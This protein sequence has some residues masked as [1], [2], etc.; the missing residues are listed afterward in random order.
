MNRK[1]R[2][3][4]AQKVKAQVTLSWKGSVPPDEHESILRAARIA[5]ARL[6]EELHKVEQAGAVKPWKFTALGEFPPLNVS[7]IGISFD[8]QPFIIQKVNGHHDHYFKSTIKC[9]QLI[10]PP[11]GVVL[12]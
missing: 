2:S 11:K 1:L 8:D 9:W 5:D 12:K 3:A 7:V 4:I 10:V 6:R